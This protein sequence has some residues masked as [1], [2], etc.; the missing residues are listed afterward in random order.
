MDNNRPAYNLKAPGRSGTGGSLHLPGRGAFPGVDDRLVEPETRME[1]IGGRRI[2]TSPALEPHAAEHSKVSKVLGFHAAP[3]YSTAVDMLTRYDVESDFASDACVYKEGLDP[4]TGGRYLEEIA[5]EVVSEQN[6]SVVREKAVRMHRR[7]VRRIF[8]VFVKGAQRVC[9]WEPKS[10]S[11]RLLD[12]GA[13]IEDACLV[14]PL[15]IAAL[16]DAVAA[17]YAVVEAL[18]AANSPAILEVEAVARQEGKAEGRQET[19]EKTLL[20]L[21]EKKFGALESGDRDR[22]TAADPDLLEQWLDRVLT[23]S[24]LHDVFSP[25]PAVS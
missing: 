15:P 25:D 3:G 12:R 23:A 8:A 7:G 16:F 13:A 2:V 17:D 4:A 11:W 19:L 18:R 20:R 9:E 5:F 1:I 22:I 6:E 21:L 10:Q 14:R 24:T